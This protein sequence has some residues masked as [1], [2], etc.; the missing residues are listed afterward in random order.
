MK[1]PCV[2]GVVARGRF[3]ALPL[4]NEIN[5]HVM[6]RNQ[7]P[8]AVFKHRID[9]VDEVHQDGVDPGLLFELAQSCGAYGLARFNPAARH[10]PFALLWWC[11]TA[12]EQNLFIPKTHHTHSRDGS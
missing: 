8:A 5:Q 2:S 10:G 7:V 1:K 4:R 3:A 6:P 12:D 9:H 11:A